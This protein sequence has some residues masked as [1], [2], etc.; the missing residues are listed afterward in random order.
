MLVLTIF[1]V[2][3]TESELR[4]YLVYDLSQVESVS[5]Q[6]YTHSMHCAVF[7]FF[8]AT[9]FQIIKNTWTHFT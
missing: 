8:F 4:V 5:I 9:M 3:D 1:S 7:F 6:Q 2:S